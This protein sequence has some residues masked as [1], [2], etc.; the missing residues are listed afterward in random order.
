MPGSRR[1]ATRITAGIGRR[2]R[3]AAIAERSCRRL[4]TAPGARG[5]TICAARSSRA[6]ATAPATSSR[7]ASGSPRST[8]STLVPSG[9]TL[10]SSSTFMATPVG[11]EARHR[12]QRRRTTIA[13]CP[14]SD[15]KASSGLAGDRGVET[16]LAI[17]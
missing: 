5:W 2:T 9:L 12:A 6:T 8:R 14:L 13:G 3:E 17:T 7:S 11:P 10:E 16:V 15:I 4:A 1:E